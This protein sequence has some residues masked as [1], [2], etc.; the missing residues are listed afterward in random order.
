MT[1][2][3]TTATTATFHPF[4][5]L[6]S[7]LRAQIWE[8]TVEPR[9]VEVGVVYHHP[10]PATVTDPDPR[11]MNKPLP[12]PVRHLRSPI[13]APAQL[14][15]CRDAREHLGRHPYHNGYQKAFSKIM[16]TPYDGFDPVP[17]DD[18]QK[19]RDRYVW[20]NF[21]VDM[22]SIGSETDLREF[23]AVA[24]QVRRLR[25]ERDLDNEYFA[26][27]ESRLIGGLFVHLAEIHLV[28]RGWGMRSGYKT[29][30]DIGFPCGPENV[31]FVDGEERGGKMMS[32]VDLDAMIDREAEEFDE[33]ERMIRVAAGAAAA[34]ALTK[35]PTLMDGSDNG[36]R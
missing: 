7:E 32:S 16:T 29:Y 31:Y 34:V 4:P 35:Y 28:C 12:P 5:R 26:Y 11:R 22:V 24:H 14:H 30:E 19:E 20:L 23:R 2:T 15:T 1:M 8:L 27:G 6:P 36:G 9:I 13:P 3:T 33:R 25:L 21:D 18:P 10:T 17:E